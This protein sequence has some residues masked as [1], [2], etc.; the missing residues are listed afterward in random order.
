[1]LYDQ[2]TFLCSLGLSYTFFNFQ[3]LDKFHHSTCTHI[4][5]MQCTVDFHSTDRNVAQPLPISI[6]G[7]AHGQM[8]SLFI[9]CLLS[10]LL[11]HLSTSLLHHLPLIYLSLS[12]FTLDPSFSAGNS[13]SLSNL[14]PKISPPSPPSAPTSTSVFCPDPQAALFIDSLGQCFCL[15]KQQI[16]DLHGLFWVCLI[17]VFAITGLISS[18]VKLG[19]SL[20][21]PLSQADIMA[22]I[23]SLACQY[24]S[25]QWVL[26]AMQS[27]ES[28]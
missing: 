4:D 13:L 11:C 12:H 14:T 24:G 23:Y 28:S 17:S 25:E 6:K 27:S 1:M 19:V 5:T 8:V 7:Q 15:S 18:P 22:R 9:L 20:L 10:I 26:H 2:G 16:T 3:F 21:G